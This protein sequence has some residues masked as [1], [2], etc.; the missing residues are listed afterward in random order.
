MVALAPA[1]VAFLLFAD[2]RV[3]IDAASVLLPER[4]PTHQ[5]VLFDK[6]D[7]ASAKAS[8]MEL[9]VLEHKNNR[10]QKVSLLGMN[11]SAETL[12]LTGSRLGYYLTA[13]GLDPSEPMD[14]EKAVLIVRYIFLT[15][16]LVCYYVFGLRWDTSLSK[17]IGKRVDGEVQQ[18]R[19][20]REAPLRVATK[21]SS[22]ANATTAC[23]DLP[24]LWPKLIKLHTSNTYSVKLG[25]LTS[26]TWSSNVFDESRSPVLAVVVRK[27]DSGARLLE[28]KAVGLGCFVLATVCSSTFRLSGLGGIEFGRLVTPCGASQL[29]G[30]PIRR[31]DAMLISPNGKQLVGMSTDP[32]GAAI[33]ISACSDG[34]CLAKV[35]RRAIAADVPHE[36]LELM[37]EPGVDVVLMLACSLAG[38]AFGPTPAMTPWC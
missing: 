17:T 9:D 22:R 2:P 15:T 35:T 33:E 18:L 20:K 36:T 31:G 12:D 7:S 28:V 16:A 3:C 10:Q 24:T 5:D 27:Q 25:K 1:P 11:A 34:R 29:A 21:S 38:V 13:I 30:A 23:R 26:D 32:E 6:V 14:S 19:A 8:E 4:R 37:A